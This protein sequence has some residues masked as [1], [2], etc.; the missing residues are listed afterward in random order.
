MAWTRNPTINNLEV[1]PPRAFGSA[2]CSRHVLMDGNGEDLKFSEMD[3]LWLWKL[4]VWCSIV[5]VGPPPFWEKSATLAAVN[6]VMNMI[7]REIFFLSFFQ[8]LVFFLLLF[9]RVILFL[10]LFQKTI[11]EFKEQKLN[12]QILLHYFIFLVISHPCCRKM[13][14]MPEMTSCFLHNYFRYTEYHEM[15]P[16]KKLEAYKICQVK[17]SAKW[18]QLNYGRMRQPVSFQ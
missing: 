4:F 9:Q 17:I 14:V 10:L 2:S 11:N 3:I 16:A 12:I 7:Q 15:E 8:I 6:T 5:W 13:L 18:D 1:R